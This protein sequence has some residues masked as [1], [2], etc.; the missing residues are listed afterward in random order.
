MNVKGQY[1]FE[2]FTVWGTKKVNFFG[3]L[4][5]LKRKHFFEFI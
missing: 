5:Y 3:F 2:F 1:I 4:I